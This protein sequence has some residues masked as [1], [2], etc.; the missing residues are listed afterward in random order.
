MVDLDAV[1]EEDNPEQ[2][3]AGPG[4]VMVVDAGT[5]QELYRVGANERETGRVDD[6]NF[7]RLDW[8]DSQTLVGITVRGTVGICRI[9]SA[10]GA[11]Q[12]FKLL[13][14]AE[15]AMMERYT[16]MQ[17]RGFRRSYVAYLPPPLNM[18]VVAASDQSKMMTIDLQNLD[19]EDGGWCEYLQKDNMM[20]EWGAVEPKQ[21]DGVLLPP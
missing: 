20:G 10:E 3:M 2:L 1:D 7:T 14:A 4:R 17:S 6:L 5:G 9:G 21:G 15:K 16:P 13:R 18:L 19:N 8:V 12:G 11:A